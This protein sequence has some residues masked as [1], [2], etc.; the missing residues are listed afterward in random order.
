MKL[1]AKGKINDGKLEFADSSAVTSLIKSLQN[2][3]VMVTI[4]PI[5]PTQTTKQTLMEYYEYTVKPFL[6]LYFV[7]EYGRPTAGVTNIDI[8]SFVCI[9]FAP[10]QFSSVP[11]LDGSEYKNVEMPI[12]LSDATIHETLT[13]LVAWLKARNLSLPKINHNAFKAE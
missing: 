10:R 2:S 8:D 9:N 13:N 5:E 11:T 6:L 12:A 3:D 7:A 1:I 4:Q